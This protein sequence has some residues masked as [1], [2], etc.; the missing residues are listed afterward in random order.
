MALQNVKD[1]HKSALHMYVY[2]A[3][4]TT[5]SLHADC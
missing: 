5:F 2:N 4:I 3:T 1:M